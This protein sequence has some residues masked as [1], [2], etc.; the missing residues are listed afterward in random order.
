MGLFS[1]HRAVALPCFPVVGLSLMLF[2]CRASHVSWKDHRLPCLALQRQHSWKQQ[3][4][5]QLLTDILWDW[6]ASGSFKRSR[7]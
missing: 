5:C 1:L 6:A 7:L 3:S 4:E 2:E